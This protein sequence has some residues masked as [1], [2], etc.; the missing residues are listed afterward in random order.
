M[1]KSSS[2]RLQ[3][4][5]NNYSSPGLFNSQPSGFAEFVGFDRQFFREFAATKN[6]QTIRPSV[7]EPSFAQELLSNVRTLFEL[8]EIAQIDKRI[9]GLKGRIIKSAL[10][11][12]PDKRHLTAF[13]PKPDTSSRTSLLALMPFA[14][15]LSVAGTLSAPESLYPML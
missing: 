14:A 5:A 15:R 7:H 10:G 12:S 6:L 13:E 9:R 11:Q 4:T 2:E 3:L 1:R 8:F